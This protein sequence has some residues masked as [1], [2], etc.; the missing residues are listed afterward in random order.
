MNGRALLLSSDPTLLPPKP[1]WCHWFQWSQG[2]VIL[3]TNTRVSPNPGKAWCFTWNNPSHETLVLLLSVLD[4]R[5]A[6]DSYVF[7]DE[8][9]KSGTPHLQGYVRWIE[10]TRPQTMFGENWSKAHWEACRD[11]VAAIA[12]CSDPEKRTPGGGI[13]SRNVL[14]PALI[15]VLALS[16][17]YAW[18]REVVELVNSPPSKRHIY[19]IWEEVGGS[20][21]SA[22][23]R[24]LAYIHGALICAGKAADIKSMVATHWIKKRF[25]PPVVVFDIP[26]TSLQYLSYTG[27]EEVKNA[28]FASTKYEV[29]TVVTPYFHVIVFA[30][31]PPTWSALST[32][33]WRVSQLRNLGSELGWGWSDCSPW[34]EQHPGLTDLD[35]DVIR[36]TAFNAKPTGFGTWQDYANPAGIDSPPL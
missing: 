28:A 16:D 22:I 18:Q 34:D 31:S 1:D 6:T 25:V 35:P 33:R 3:K 8:I 20:G 5:E 24:Y 9:G 36:N 14:L 13:W 10:K 29:A 27:L 19:W 15:E 30:N 32:D 26:R 12:Y 2:W 4:N 11:P 7:Q 17:M 21:K 23:C